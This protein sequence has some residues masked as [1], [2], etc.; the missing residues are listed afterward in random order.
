MIKTPIFDEIMGDT[1][2]P[3]H[4]MCT[5][6]INQVCAACDNMKVE[7]TTNGGASCTK[8][9]CKLGFWTG[10]QSWNRLFFEP[11][12]EAEKTYRTNMLQKWMITH[13]DNRR[14]TK[15]RQGNPLC[16]NIP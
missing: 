6:L 14:K 7:Q 5:E 3:A 2:S 12:V 15:H 4:K 1:P 16:K 10:G 8:S 13:G 11:D 9:R